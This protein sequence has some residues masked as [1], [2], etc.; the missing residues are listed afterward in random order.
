LLDEVGKSQRRDEPQCLPRANQVCSA[1]ETRRDKLAAN[2]LAFIQCPLHLCRFTA[3]ECSLRTKC[4]DSYHSVSMTQGRPLVRFG[5]CG[6]RPCSGD[7]KRAVCE[8]LRPLV[9]HPKRTFRPR[10]GQHPLTCNQF[11]NIGATGLPTENRWSCLQ[12]TLRSPLVGVS[13]GRL[14]SRRRRKR[15]LS[16]RWAVQAYSSQFR[17]TPRVVSRRS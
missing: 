11:L 9:E 4:G 8:S 17:R 13:S 6:R 2:Y 7:N 5:A 10:V 15:I 16:H 1:S 12:M 14:G 3:P